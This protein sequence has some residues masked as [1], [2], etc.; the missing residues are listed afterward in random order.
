MLVFL[1]FFYYILLVQVAFD[2]IIPLS[3]SDG[4]IKGKTKQP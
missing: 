4:K 1:F 3:I 2:P